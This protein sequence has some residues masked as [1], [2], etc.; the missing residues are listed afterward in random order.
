MEKRIEE[1]KKELEAKKVELDCRKYQLKRIEEK[2]K[3]LEQEQIEL[4]DKI[5][6]LDAQIISLELQIEEENKQEK[7]YTKYG[8]KYDEDGES[9]DYYWDEIEDEFTERDEQKLA[10]MTNDEKLKEM[11]DLLEKAYDE[12]EIRKARCTY[13]TKLAEALDDYYE[14]ACEYDVDWIDSIKE[15]EDEAYKSDKAVVEWGDM[16]QLFYW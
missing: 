9:N 15:R 8:L 3:E 16:H 7:V 14:E 4:D 5:D 1:L 11:F 12:V 6:D 10:E 2:L 13:L